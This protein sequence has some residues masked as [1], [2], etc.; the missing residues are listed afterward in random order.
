MN[1]NKKSIS[2]PL[3]NLPLKISISYN[4]TINQSTV[5]NINDPI[6]KL[7]NEYDDIEKIQ[8]INECPLTQFLYFNRE[9]IQKILYESNENIHFKY[10][11]KN[12][13]L[14]FY[15]YLFLL[16]ND[17]TEILNYTYDIEYI[18]VMNDKQKNNDNYIN[19]LIMSKIII[20]LSKNYKEIN[21]CYGDENEVEL[22]TIIN[23][24][25]NIIR[26]YIEGLEA[27]EIDLNID[28]F[29]KLEIDEL[30]I[31]IINKLILDTKIEYSEKIDYLTEQLDIENIYLNKN[32][33]NEISKTLNSKELYETF[34]IKEKEDLN[35]EIKIDFYYILLKYIL[36]N[37]IYIY[38]IPFLIDTRK[39]IIKIIKE[40]KNIYFSED[41]ENTEK[42]KYVIEIFICSN[43]FFKK[44]KKKIVGLANII[45]DRFK[46]SK[47]NSSK[48]FGKDEDYNNRTQNII[49]KNDTSI[50]SKISE[51][52]APREVSELDCLKYIYKIFHNPEYKEYKES[53]I[54]I[55]D[56]GNYLELD[57]IF[58]QLNVEKKDIE[59]LKEII[60][61]TNF[62]NDL[63]DSKNFISFLQRNIYFK[64]S[65]E[66][67]NDLKKNVPHDVNPKSIQNF[68]ECLNNG[69]DSTSNNNGE[70]NLTK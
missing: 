36:K 14:S 50:I 2:P 5:I 63:K 44:K 39:N 70:E 16:I 57:Q 53:L 47:K 54:K 68:K 34:L 45:K 12:M 60:K 22:N 52:S 25:D 69:K 27:Y 6:V 38:H 1:Y 42:T 58:K 48:N 10:S 24:N 17:Q 31:L 8:K 33:L 62:N 41:N 13:N 9:K 11:E 46:F 3:D 55:C 19:K 28:E 32:M 30:Y 66:E 56:S 37:S 23:N 26:E 15:F 64:K 7:L 49:N 18:K 40:K 35:K 29:Y 4:S 20:K 51:I 59:K 67:I 21:D 43:R 61:H 65:I